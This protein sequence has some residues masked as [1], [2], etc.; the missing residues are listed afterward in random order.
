M[1]KDR[2]YCGC[3]TAGGIY[4]LGFIGTAVY[5]IIN[6]TGFWNGVWGFLKALVWPA[7]LTYGVFNFLGL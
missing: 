2:N 4:G 3:G 1:R 5:Y 7:F 6:A